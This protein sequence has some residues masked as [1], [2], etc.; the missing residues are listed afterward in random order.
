MPSLKTYDIFIS[1][2]WKYGEQ[3]KTLIE[4]LKKA[5]NFY[6]RN[7]SAPEDNPLKNLNRTDVTTKSEITSAI[8]R[9]IKPVN[10]VI[11]ISGMYANNREWMEKEIEIAQE[12]NKPIIAVKPWGNTNVPT[13]IQ[14][15]SDVIVSWNTSSIVEA[16]RDYSL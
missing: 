14:G 7:Y 5:N 3:Y 9:K 15:V 1:H 4:L 13:Y 12:Y 6:F 2:A 16:I 8:K 10:A 11:V